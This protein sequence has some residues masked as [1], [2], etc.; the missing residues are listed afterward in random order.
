ME[1][2]FEEFASGLCKVY[3]RNP[4]MFA[5]VTHQRLEGL[6]GVAWKLTTYVRAVDK[7]A[8]FACSCLAGK[9]CSSFTLG[10]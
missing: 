7:L 9:V 3:M 8:R 10:L 1:D 6:Q 5:Q 4:G 2:L